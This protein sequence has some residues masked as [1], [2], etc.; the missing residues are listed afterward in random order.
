MLH[1]LLEIRRGITAVIG[2]GGKTT[3][4]QVL[5]RELSRVGTVILSTSTKIYPMPDMENFTDAPEETIQSAALKNRLI[6]VGTPTPQGK[7]A[8]PQ[9]AFSRLAELAD[10][11]LV[12]A[13][14]S[15]GRPLK[16]HLPYEPVIPPG[17]NQVI[18]VVGMSAMG[19]PINTC[20]HR[21]ELY[22]A[23]AGCRTDDIAVPELAA[24]VLK[25]EHLHTRAFLN[26]VHSV[27]EYQLA[28]QFAQL[29]PCP[30]AA[31]SLREGIY[32]C[33]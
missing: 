3:L 5:G 14:G 24:R 23:I 20:A 4:L 1:E 26:Q 27:E 10:F 29:L 30:V 13:D 21:P 33:L 9:T 6:C 12:E 19:E 11:V 8:A 28:Y 16:A 31:G 32:L 17:A 2:G 18:C 25:R 7:L 22:A 15:N